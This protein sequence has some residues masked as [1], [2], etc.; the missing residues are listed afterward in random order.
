MYKLPPIQKTPLH[1]TNK[2]WHTFGINSVRILK[3]ITIY[4]LHFN[5]FNNFVPLLNLS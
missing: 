5:I 1:K 2:S 4:L 3:K